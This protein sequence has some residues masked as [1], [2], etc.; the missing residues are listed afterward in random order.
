M[1]T[2]ESRGYERFRFSEESDEAVKGDVFFR[3]P[4][5]NSRILP[6]DFHYRHLVDL[7]GFG[8]TGAVNNVLLGFGGSLKTGA[9]LAGNH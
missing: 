2:G 5:Q 6:I 8:F 3:D 9:R 4:G 7:V 1:A